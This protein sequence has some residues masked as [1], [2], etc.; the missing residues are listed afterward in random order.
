VESIIELLWW[1]ALAER[2]PNFRYERETGNIHQHNWYAPT[3]CPSGRIP[4]TY[5]I[6]RLKAMADEANIQKVQLLFIGL[7]LARDWVGMENLRKWLEAQ[8]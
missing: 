2:W 7:I 5:I 1:M 6:E 3:A 8:G 4:F